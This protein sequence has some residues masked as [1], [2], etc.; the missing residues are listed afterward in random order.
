MAA[1]VGIYQPV[2]LSTGTSISC[3]VG[4]LMK[5]A[6]TKA[7]PSKDSMGRS[8][9]YNNNLQSNNNFH[10]HLIAGDKP[11]SNSKGRTVVSAS[12]NG[13]AHQSNIQ[14]ANVPQYKSGVRSGSNNE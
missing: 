2:N 9:T 6:C 3:G 8:I 1:Q 13:K 14:I 4:P 5:N 12:S 10:N 7:Q 11:S